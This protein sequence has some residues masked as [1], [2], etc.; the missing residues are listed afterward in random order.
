MK[1]VSA[2]IAIILILMIV[3]AL[4]S[5]TW[6]WFTGI[7]GGL[8]SSATNATS[9]A[10]TTVNME[11]RLEAARYYPGVGV[12]ATMRNTGT[13]NV[14]LSKLGMYVDGS[15]STY[16]PNSGNL[17]P[18]MTTTITVTNTTAAC[19]YKVLKITLETGFEDYRTIKC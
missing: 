13:M 2:I 5:L 6:T 8:Q 9:S 16:S 10:T 14:N 11:V 17:A 4:T 19:D 18:D 1:G 3:V 7:F 15:L 12:N